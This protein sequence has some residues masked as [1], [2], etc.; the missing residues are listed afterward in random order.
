S[1][2]EYFYDMLLAKLHFA[3]ISAF[4]RTI[5]ATFD[6]VTPSSLAA[7]IFGGCFMSLQIPDDSD[8]Q[9]ILRDTFSIYMEYLFFVIDCFKP[10][11]T[12]RP[13]SSTTDIEVKAQDAAAKIKILETKFRHMLDLAQR[14]QSNSWS[15][16]S[17]P[18]ADV[19][20]FTAHKQDLVT[21]SFGQVHKVRESSTREVYARKIIHLGNRGWGSEALEREVQAEFETMKKLTHIHIVKVLISQKELDSFSILMLPV[22]DQDLRAYLETCIRDEYPPE[23]L[24]SILH[25]FG[26][27]LHALAFAHRCSVIHQDIKPSNILIK[28]EGGR[29]RIYLADFGMAKDFS[30]DG[31]S[32][33]ANNNVRGT[34]IYRAPE[35]RLRQARGRAADIFS[36]GCVF[37][38][39]FTVCC[40]R[41]LEQ[42]QE[43]RRARDKDDQLAFRENIPKVSS[44]LH[45]LAATQDEDSKGVIPLLI[46]QMMREDPEKRPIAPKAIQ[47][48]KNTDELSDLFCPDCI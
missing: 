13:T 9:S 24:S 14:R 22:A 25:W 4:A 10:G 48:L 28:D 8:L 23:A 19:Q 5:D 36:L 1:R 21:G 26:C 6:Y 12:P 42:Y 33:T 20:H 38:E 40:G 27:Q 15:Y 31:A 46:R 32:A 45:D 47:T 30:E 37:S 44:W 2:K 11:F 17:N 43:F 16:G 41:S 7:L 3:H 29:L 39:M 35:V 34:P 18:P